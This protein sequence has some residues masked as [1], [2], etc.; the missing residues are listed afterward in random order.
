LTLVL[1]PLFNP[2]GN[3]AIDPGNRQLE[4]PKL[5]GQLGPDSGVG[6][7]VNADKI[8]LSRDYLRATALTCHQPAP[9][10]RPCPCLRQCPRP[11]RALW[12]V[13]RGASFATKTTRR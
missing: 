2:D 6:T 12:R 4:L 11:G 3:D 10:L 13:W 7:R 9:T 1:V 5:T 8:N